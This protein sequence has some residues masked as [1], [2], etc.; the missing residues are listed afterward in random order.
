MKTNSKLIIAYII[1]FFLFLISVFQLILQ[2]TFLDANDTSTMEALLDGTGKEPASGFYFQGGAI[3]QLLLTQKVL[4]EIED[5]DLPNDS[6]PEDTKDRL[7]RVLIGQKLQIFFYVFLAI[8]SCTSFLSLYFRAFFFAFLNRVLYALGIAYAISVM[9]TLL[10]AAIRN[11]QTAIWALPI[12]LFSFG[13]VIGLLYLFIIIGRTFGKKTADRFSSLRNLREDEA[14]FRPGSKANDSWWHPFL[15]FLGI[16]GL[17]TL[18]GN[19]IYIPLFVI[20]KNYTDQF[21]IL[22]ILSII[23][24]SVFYIKNYLKFGKSA[25]LGKYQNLAL[26]VS[27]L[28]L[29]L[30]RIV[31]MILLVLSL[32]IV[33]VVFLL[34][35]LEID[36]GILE[37]LFPLI[38][39]GQ[40]L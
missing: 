35:L 14:E 38:N 29:R 4:A 28:Q 5:P 6:Q 30:I 16:V 37:S 12:L 32:V 26:G 13:W 3:S 22:L 1:P 36:F 40:N 18:I 27:Y 2:P 34:G 8:L 39:S 11:P 9:P 20:Q 10:A 31:L 33:F 21:G 23:L 24:L 17:G 15:H 7:G 19:L 25:E